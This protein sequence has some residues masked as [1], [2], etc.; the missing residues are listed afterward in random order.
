MRGR[1]GHGGGVLL[2]RAVEHAAAVP[3]SAAHGD[4]D[5]TVLPVAEP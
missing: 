2:R 1:R 4:L 5:R 3:A